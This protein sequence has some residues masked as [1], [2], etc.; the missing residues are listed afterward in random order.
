MLRI[1][2]VILLLANLLYA[3][4][5]AGGLRNFGLL[6]PQVSEPERIAAQIAPQSLRVL[7]PA[8]AARLEAEA[9]SAQCLQAGPLAAGLLPPLR[10]KLAGWPLGSWTLVEAT[11]TAAPAG[12]LL[13]LPVVD[14]ALRARLADLPALLGTAEL[15]PCR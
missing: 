9:R 15:Q 7:P 3:A 4:W 1:T 5:A 11:P 8:D 6:P 2:L 14:D 13:R 10:D 12:T